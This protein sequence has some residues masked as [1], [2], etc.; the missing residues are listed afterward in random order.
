MGSW[1][2]RQRTDGACGHTLNHRQVFSP[3]GDAACFDA[4]NA[5][6]EIMVTNR[7]GRI[8]LA[9]GE[10]DWIYRVPAAGSFG[11][12]VG[13]V[14]C[15]PQRERWIFI[16]GLRNCDAVKPYGATRRFGALLDGRDPSRATR[17]AEA[18]CMH[19][20]PPR[21]AL[22]GGTHAHS[23]SADGRAISFTYNDAW[24][25]QRHHAGHGPPD[26]RT[27]GVMWT[28][29]HVDV[30]DRDGENFPGAC[31]A[32]L[33]ASV[34]HRA[35]P[36]TDEIES[37]REECFLGPRS[38]AIAFLGRVRTEQGGTID[39][40]FVARWPEMPPLAS[41]SSTV[42]ADERLAPPDFV[43]VERVTRSENRTFPGVSGP[44][45]WLVASPDG[46]RVYCPMRDDDGMA[47]VA[48]VDVASGGVEFLTRLATPLESPLALDRSGERISWMSAGRI[49]ILDMAKD[50]VQW[51]FD[52]RERLEVSWG[53][54]HFLPQ[55]DGLLFHAYPRNR[56]PKWQQLWTLHL[57]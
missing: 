35:R 29:R 56:N 55:D 30:P 15:H 23:W 6:T 26:L 48:A 47:Q 40:I 11:P 18:R 21:G 44:R 22:R 32:M 2:L 3:S 41:G 51:S 17:P 28:D 14:A 33:V 52:V 25:E 53:A 16:H 9:T 24:V 31:H 1:E 43:R 7:V 37:A 38:R 42:D 45:S 34:S 12:G 27:V 36:G 5:D 54:F 39:E 13:A 49:A 50:E 57:H 8:D 19:P 20:H 46:R 10:I 4:R